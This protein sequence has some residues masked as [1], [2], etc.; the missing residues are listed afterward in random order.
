MNIGE[1]MLNFVVCDDDIHMLDR[2]SSLL[3]KVIIA[4]DF[5][6]KI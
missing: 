3:E 1:T 6:A 2:I 4:N 5:D